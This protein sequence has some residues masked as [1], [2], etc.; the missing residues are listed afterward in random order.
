MIDFLQHKFI[1]SSDYISTT[2]Q[3]PP[4]KIGTWL[5]AVLQSAMDGVIV[6]DASGKIVLYNQEAD[7]MFGYGMQQIL[8]K[9]MDMLLPVR[10]RS[11][12]RLQINRF[13]KTRLNGRRLRIKLDLIG[14]RANG[15]EFFI[16]TSVS[17]VTVRG[18]IFLAMILRELMSQ[19]DTALTPENTDLRRLAV[20][21]QQANEVEKRRFSKELY[22]DLGQRLSVL[23]LDLDWLQNNLP[24]TDTPIPERIVQMQRMLGNIITRTKSIASTLRPPLLDDF[25]LIPAIEWITE[26]FY[27]KTG[28]SCTVENHGVAI[29]AGDPAESAI[30][31]VVQESL[32]NVERHAKASHVK[33]ILRHHDRCL[34]IVIQDDGVGMKAGHENKPGCYGLIAM[35]E[36]VYILG[37]TIS[38]QNVEPTG[39]AIRASIPIEQVPTSSTPL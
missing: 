33:I 22:D 20:S 24:D 25:G 26:N 28:I 39:F 21:S 34:D 5:S 19:P 13:A 38:I 23:K 4:D 35:Q 32:L 3:F 1:Q 17:R 27:K 14:L 29:K 9:P 37:G 16:E 36:R 8:G 7:R 11:E 18:E 31:R 12:H 30:F 2:P 6:I 10:L 15:E